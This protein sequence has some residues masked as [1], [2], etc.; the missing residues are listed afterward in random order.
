MIK[1]GEKEV[2]IF[3]EKELNIDQIEKKRNEKQDSC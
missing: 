2:I 1:E 3:I